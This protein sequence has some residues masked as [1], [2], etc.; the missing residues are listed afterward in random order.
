MLVYEYPGG[1]L[2]CTYESGIDGVP[3]SNSG[4]MIYAIGKMVSVS[5]IRHL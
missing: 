2:S 1:K 3:N 4:L 5:I